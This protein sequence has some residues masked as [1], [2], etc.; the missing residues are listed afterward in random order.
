MTRLGLLLASALLLGAAAP[1]GNPSTGPEIVQHGTTSGIVPC[2][3]CHGS[4][5]QGN[6]AI[7]APAL[8][9]LPQ[10]ATLA[11]LASIADGKLGSNV[12]MRSIARS[13]TGVQ[14]KAVAAYFATLA[15]GKPVLS[16]VVTGSARLTTAQ[17][18]QVSTGAEIMQH[19]TSSGAKPCM[20]C[21]GTHLQGDA[22]FGAP[23]LAGMPARK[24]LAALRA[25]AA[26]KTG[27]NAAM[28]N[29][30][31]SLSPTQRQAVA[32]FL[33]LTTPTARRHPASAAKTGRS[34]GTS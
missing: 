21:H 17:I 32:A 12:V 27:D 7:G 18:I 33:A 2:M 16:T 28:R 3:A 31:R 20:A 11:A 1:N 9:G 4:H 26:G 25:I 30:A 14:R 13:L 10:S 15:R 29:T 19:G 34:G 24:T 6:A 22:A 8:A 23:P 5:L